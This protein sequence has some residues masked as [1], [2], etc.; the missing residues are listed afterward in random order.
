MYSSLQ[1][2]WIEQTTN[3]TKKKIESLLQEF[4]RSIIKGMG[5]RKK[6]E[7][8]GIF[9]EVDPLGRPSSVAVKGASH[10]NDMLLDIHL[11]FC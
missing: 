1:C 4:R 2:S 10:C 11:T 9:R 8:N 5:G 6:K 7:K 3:I